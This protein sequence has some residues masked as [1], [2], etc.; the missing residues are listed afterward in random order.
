MIYVASPY[1]IVP[2]HWYEAG[3]SQ[4]SIDHHMLWVMRNRYKAAEKYVATKI[5]QGI[6][7][8]SPIVHSHNIANEYDLPKT[9]EFWADINHKYLD[10]CS[11]VHILQMDCWEESAGIHDEIKYAIKKDI[12]IK[13][14]EWEG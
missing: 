8:F 10:V 1:S 6:C 9:F 2:R 4:V 12:P 3:M 14:V 7:C 5:Q 13:Y 11:E